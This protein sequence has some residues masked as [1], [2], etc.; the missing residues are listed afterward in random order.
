L[1]ASQFTSDTACTDQLNQLAAGYAAIGAGDYV[2]K[3][4]FCIRVYNYLV[5]EGLTD[6][7]LITVYASFITKVKGL[8]AT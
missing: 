1:T 4:G 5:N 8:G 6:G 2:T 7:D 3:S